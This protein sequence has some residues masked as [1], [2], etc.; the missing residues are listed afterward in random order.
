MKVDCK[1][2]KG[3]EYVKLN[4][5]PQNQQE[6]LLDTLAH[7]FFI[8][9]MMDGIVVHQCLQYKDYDR[10]Y[11]NVFN[12]KTPVKVIKVAER[13]IEVGVSSNLALNKI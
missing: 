12:A 4:E 5:L 10:W 13:A 6:K 2:Y 9:I 11:E 7:D 8:K 3:I 1:I